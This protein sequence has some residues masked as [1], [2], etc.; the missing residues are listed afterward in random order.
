MTITV[1]PATLVLNYAVEDRPPDGWTVVPTSINNGGLFDPVRGK[2]KWGPFSDN[3]P[4]TN[5]YQ[6]MPPLDA[7]AVGR[8]VGG[9]AF[10]G[11]TA[12]FVGPRETV[13]S[14]T[15]PARFSSVRMLPGAGVE[16]TL[17]G[18]GGGVVTIQRSTDLIEWSPVETLATSGGPVVFR[19]S[20]AANR[21]GN[22][23]RAVWQ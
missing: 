5:S 13:R 15:P 23:Y 19:D 22:F 16:L 1:S 21:L 20:S 6:V 7:G 3:T 8:F 17:Q 2:V 14:G 4:R 11:Q 12:D 18:G 9:A 10:D